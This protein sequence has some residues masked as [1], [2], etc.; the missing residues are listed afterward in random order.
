M[1]GGNIE[2]NDSSSGDGGGVFNEGTFTM[3]GGSIRENQN[4]AGGGGVFNRGTFIVSGDVNISGNVRG[5]TLKNGVIT[6]GTTANVFLPNGKT[7]TVEEGKPLAAT[8]R[9]GIT[10]EN[11]A[12]YPT[13]V[14]GTTDITG[15]FSDNADYMLEGNGS[16]GLKLTDALVTVSGVK[17]LNETG[18][19]EMTGG[20]TYDGKAVAYDDSGVSYTPTV[21]GVTLTYTWQ[22]L[23]G[24]TYGD[25]TAA[26][27]DTGSYRLLVSAVKNGYTL[28]TQALEFTIN[29]YNANGSEYSTNADIHD[30]SGVGGYWQNVDYVVTAADG[31]QLSETNTVD[32]SWVES[33]TRS[34]ETNSGSLRFYVRNRTSGIISEVITKHYKIDKTPPVISGIEDG[35]FYYEEV[36]VTVTDENFT[37]WIINGI[38]YGFSAELALPTDGRYTTDILYVIAAD[39]AGN[40]ARFTVYNG[41]NWGDWVSN[42]DGTHTRTSLVNAENTITADCHGGEAT[43][44]DRAI[45]DDCKTAYGELAPHNHT[46]LQHFPAKEATKDAEGNIEYWYC[47]G[48]DRYYS[49]MD[50]TMEIQK[51]DTVIEKP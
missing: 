11:P 31:W 5:G 22:K 13:V 41:H 17:L 33:L 37:H 51:A 7:I 40:S 38:P 34:E 19:E 32:G 4:A 47:D 25:L 21:L 9:I 1:N 50:G 48:C 29:S 30:P 23:N 46:N 8:A 43:C 42:G 27:K 26:P 2:K 49:D 12:S 28:G 24:E 20:K 36:T 3:N 44:K 35:K 45:C 14:T 10:A 39:R 6:G 16:N 18:G 15:F